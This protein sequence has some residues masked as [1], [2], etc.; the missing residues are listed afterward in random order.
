[1]RLRATPKSFP[2]TSHAVSRSDTLSYLPSP[3]PAKDVYS[4]RC[5]I[6]NPIVCVSAPWTAPHKNK[7]PPAFP[8]KLPLYIT[9]LAEKD[10]EMKG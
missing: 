4:R 3:H 6:L 10:M 5:L 2:F 8:N 7:S 9:R 1:M